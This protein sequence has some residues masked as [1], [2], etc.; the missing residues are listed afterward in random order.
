ML[1]D[2]WL[3][4]IQSDGVSETS[5]AQTKKFALPTSNFIGNINLRVGATVL[6]A[7]NDANQESLLID[8]IT[9][10]RVVGDGFATIV[11]L[12]PKELRAIMAPT[13]G[14]MPTRNFTQ[15]NDEVETIDFPICMGRFLYDTEYILP[16]QLFKN[17]S[18]EIEYNLSDI[19]D[20]G[21]DTG[22]MAFWLDVDEYISNKDPLSA[23]ILKRTEVKSATTSSGDM[24]VDMPLGGKYRRV[25]TMLED[26]DA[27]ENVDITKLQF[28]INN[29]A[30]IP[31]TVGWD[32]LQRANK[33]EFNM[34][35]A[36]LAGTVTKANADTIITELGSISGYSTHSEAT[37]T[38]STNIIASATIGGGTMT[39]DVNN[40]A[41]YTTI[42][43]IRFM[44]QSKAAIPECAFITFDKG[45]NI[46][47]CPDSSVWNDAK[48]RLTGANAN[49]TYSVVLEEV[50]SI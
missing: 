9:K 42:A 11:D 43:A 26:D 17:L 29:G 40:E 5:N 50:V 41:D 46:N 3:R 23:K 27:E 7:G 44:A 24:D 34:P 13:L 33:D 28:R 18:L 21:W 14:A 37:L 15:L 6:N 16:A 1:Q 35:Y 31:I 47:L 8:Q 25:M 4:T 12:K 22:S 2:N 32:M 19:A 49:G 20:P 38:G 45:G 36:E 39:M 48:L 10:I 30:E